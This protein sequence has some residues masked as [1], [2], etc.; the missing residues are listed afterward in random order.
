MRTDYC[1]CT[2]FG[3]PQIHFADRADVVRLE[4]LLGIGGIC[5]DCEILLC[6]RSVPG[7]L[8]GRAMRHGLPTATVI[9]AFVDFLITFVIL[10]LC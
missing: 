6:Y 7:A 2:I 10:I 4:K 1:P 8:P 9:V 5:L 3:H